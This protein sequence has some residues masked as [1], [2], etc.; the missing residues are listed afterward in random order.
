MS[1]C[2][3][4]GCLGAAVNGRGWCGKH[5]ARWRT[6]G[7]PLK[8]L[9]RGL[10]PGVINKTKHGHAKRGHATPEYRTWLGMIGRCHCP[11]ATR[12]RDYGGRGVVVC[13]RWRNSF[14]NFLA[15]MGPKPTPQHSIDR[16]DNSG[17][18]EPSNCRWATMREQMRNRSGNRFITIDGVTQCVK[19]WERQAGL[20]NSCISGRLNRGWPINRDLLQPPNYRLRLLTIDGVERSLSEWARLAGQTTSIIQ[21]RLGRGWLHKDAVFVPS[22]PRGRSFYATQAAAIR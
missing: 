13:E 17:N 14:E 6:H 8:T 2:S 20:V 22:Q 18:Y 11:T 12:Y 21:K 10:K 3:V 4:K 15:D 19:D 16:I 1:T 5:Y 7:D 9:P